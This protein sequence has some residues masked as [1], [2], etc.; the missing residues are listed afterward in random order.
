LVVLT[1]LTTLTTFT[2][3]EANELSNHRETLIEDWVAERG[4]FELSVPLLKLADEQFL[5]KVS[6]RLRSCV[7]P[8]PVGI[9]QLASARAGGSIMRESL[10]ALDEVG[11]SP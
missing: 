2:I 5:N 6:D 4:Q 7:N 11:G 3:L 9:Y 8:E 1:L 10:Q